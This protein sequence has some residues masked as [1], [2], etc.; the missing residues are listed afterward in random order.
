[1]AARIVVIGSANTDLVATV[2][3]LPVAGETVVGGDFHIT[4]GGKGANQAVAAARA[5]AEVSFVGCVG[6]DD[7]GR[8]RLEELRGEGV[9]V[10]HVRVSKNTHSGVAIIMVAEGG[11][12]LI[13]AVLGANATVSVGDVDRARDL[14]T[15]ADMLLLQLEIPY[16]TVCHALR[17][18]KQVGTATVLNP[19]P[20]PT[21][22]LPDDIWPRVDYLTPNETEVQQFGRHLGLGSVEE[23]VQRMLRTGVGAVVLTR[24]RQGA[25]IISAQADTEVAAY[26][27]EAIDAVGAGDAFAGG[28][29][30]AL[31]EGRNVEDAVCFANATAALSVT[32]RGA[33]AAMPA[34]EEI[35]RLLA[36]RNMEGS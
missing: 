18:A 9:D 26:E 3:R 31:A 6:D 35:D 4:P 15:E 33:Q 36:K 12:N 17:L 29:A 25:R 27:V 5:G 14:V 22:P 21:E 8:K 13:A 32:R 30:C 11:E 7:F 28:L 23:T 10:A 20:A 16:E 19:A 24:G 2:P 34:R 1:M